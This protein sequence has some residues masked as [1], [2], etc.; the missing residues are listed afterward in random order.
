[1][2][3]LLAATEQGGLGKSKGSAKAPEEIVKI[4]NCQ[5]EKIEIVEANLEETNN[6]IYKKV[7]EQDKALIIGGDHSITFP[8]FKAFIK[9]NPG[10]GLIIF[11]AHPDC[12]NNF[13]PP[14]HEDFVRVLI[15]E[16]I[17]SP[18]KIILVGLRQFDPIE[19]KFLKDNKIRYFSMKQ[20]FDYGIKDVCETVMESALAWPG[21]YLS[22][23]IDVVD[24]AFAPGTGY[25]EP[26]GLNSAEFLNFIKRIKK[27][28]N[29]KMVDIVEISPERDRDELTVRLGA[30]IIQELNS[31]ASLEKK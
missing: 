27:L 25:R 31:N 15:E 19:L 7:L 20:I 24:P 11:D 28:K 1:M 4:I 10:A 26:G 16:K 23:D 22:I 5:F 18:Y 9:N 13:Q 8:A 2:K 12:V 21:V 14:T 17:L 3:I 30:K 6:N 29:L